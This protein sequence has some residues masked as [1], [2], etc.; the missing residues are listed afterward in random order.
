VDGAVLRVSVKTL[1]EAHARVGRELRSRLTAALAAAGI[2]D[3]MNASRF[4][5]RP[6]T[7]PG[8]DVA[9][10]AGGS[11]SAGDPIGGSTSDSASSAPAS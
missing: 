3:A 11:G 10:D 2:T 1:S 8:D 9:D 6:P 4:Y 7:E 5:V